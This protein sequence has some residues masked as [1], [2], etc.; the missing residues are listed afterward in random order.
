MNVWYCVPD[1]F[2]S[3]VLRINFS[4]AYLWH[5]LHSGWPIYEV[6]S[7][8]LLFFLRFLAKIGCKMHTK[9]K[10]I[11]QKDKRMN[12]TPKIFS[13]C[14]TNVFWNKCGF[15]KF[16]CLTFGHSWGRLHELW[17][18]MPPFIWEPSSKRLHFWFK[19]AKA[20]RRT[21]YELIFSY[22]F[23]NVN[24]CKMCWSVAA[25]FWKSSWWGGI[26]SHLKNKQENGRIKIVLSNNK[27]YG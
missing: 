14:N 16:L 1:P 10:V 20:E 19:K 6:K 18:K 8:N 9:Y 23:L 12:D 3:A 27:I 2:P 21:A 22:R 26:S 5:R 15:I 4:A 7:V 24:I 17:S 25:R 11:R 13:S